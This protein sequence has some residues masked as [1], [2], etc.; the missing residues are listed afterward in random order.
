MNTNNNYLAVKSVT[1]KTVVTA[2]PIAL[3]YFSEV[4]TVYMYVHKKYIH[5]HVHV[6]TSI[7]GT[8]VKVLL[9]PCSVGCSCSVPTGV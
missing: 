8:C 1:V 6:Y 7:S 5:V 9:V 2:A 4:F 3:P